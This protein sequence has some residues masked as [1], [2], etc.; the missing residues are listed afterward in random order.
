MQDLLELSNSPSIF[1][2]TCKVA[3]G[4]HE[5]VID[6]LESNNVDSTCENPLRRNIITCKEKYLDTFIDEVQGLELN[7]TLT[8][9][10]QPL[11]YYIPVFDKKL[12]IIP[13]LPSEFPFVALSLKDSITGGVI[14]K[15]GCIHEEKNVGLR[16]LLLQTPCFKGKK[17]LLFSSGSDTLIESIWYKRDDIDFFNKIAKMGFYA[18]TGFN[19]SLFAGECALGHQLN[20]KRSLVSSY[21]YEQ[22]GILTIPHIYALTHFH[23]KRWAK[24]LNANPN[25]HY[26][27]V[28]CQL[29]TSYKDISLVIQSIK[30]IFKAVPDVHAVL[31]GFPIDRIKDFGYDIIKLHFADSLPHKRARNYRRLTF[32]PNEMKMEIIKD[33]SVTIAELTT[34]NFQQRLACLAEI[35]RRLVQINPHRASA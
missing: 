22:A 4:I 3:T 6:R 9:V 20:M 34:N 30:A 25:I 31:H 29:Q 33:D 26:F 13:N 16:S 15:A 27:T 24:W 18:A 14:H 7:T 12:E 35:K 32:R 21:L 2:L 19:F 28:N 8:S 23:I 5:P 11:P 17:I 1:S 10:I